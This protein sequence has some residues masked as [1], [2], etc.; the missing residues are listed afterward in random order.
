M[1][2]LA[3]VTPARAWVSLRYDWPV[4]RETGHARRRVGVADLALANVSPSASRPQARGCRVI[5][6]EG[7]TVSA[8]TPA[9]AWVSLHRLA[10]EPIIFCHARRR[11]GV[12][13]DHLRGLDDAKS[14]PQARGCR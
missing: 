13:F 4:F 12:A 1:L 7:N 10:T 9:G 2:C 8:V 14:R 11:V 5:Y 6:G 3:S